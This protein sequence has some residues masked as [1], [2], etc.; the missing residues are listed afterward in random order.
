[1]CC[2]GIKSFRY[3]GYIYDSHVQL[4]YLNARFYDSKIA[5]FM[6][7]DPYFKAHNTAG[8]DTSAMMQTLNLYVY[9]MNNPLKYQDHTGLAAGVSAGNQAILDAHGLGDLADTHGYV[10]ATE[11]ANALRASGS[12]GGSATLVDGDYSNYDWVALLIVIGGNLKNEGWIGNAIVNTGDLYNHGWIETATV[13]HGNLINSGIIESATVNNGS[14]YNDGLIG[15]LEL[16]SANVSTLLNNGLI[17]NLTIGSGSKAN[18]INHFMIGSIDTGAG[19]AAAIMNNGYIGN[20]TTGGKST[21]IIIN[22]GAIDKIVGG[23]GSAVHLAGNMPEKQ[24]GVAPDNWKEALARLP[25][26][27]WKS[28]GFDFSYGVGLERNIRGGPAQLNLGGTLIKQTHSFTHNEYSQRNHAT[29]GAGMELWRDK[30]GAKM[31]GSIGWTYSSIEGYANEYGVPSTEWT[32]GAFAGNTFAGL[33]T[34]GRDNDWTISF[35]GGTYI[36]VGWDADI[37]FNISE[38]YRQMGWK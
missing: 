27:V 17:G 12:S 15:A 16:H 36:I 29:L 24:V 28:M 5:R 1:M 10:H 6:S 22:I 18:I 13:D 11:V 21:A 19:S 4:Y 26:A 38:F 7:E 37:S 8:T 30:L 3:A 2:S 33:G 9:V 23:K 20:L 25:E 35:G 32:V 34:D 31:E 14:V